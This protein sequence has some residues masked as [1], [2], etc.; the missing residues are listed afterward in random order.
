M[1]EGRVLVFPDS[2]VEELDDP[3][4]EVF[5]VAL[6]PGSRISLPEVV[7]QRLGVLEGQKLV[8]K[9]Q[10][11]ETVL[12]VSLR[13]VVDEAQDQLARE[14]RARASRESKE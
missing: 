11:D 9:I 13:R 3:E 7:R 12:I 6:E 5:T 1:K 4:S 10:R 2:N 14:R 8:I